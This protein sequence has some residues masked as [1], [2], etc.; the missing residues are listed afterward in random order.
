MAYPQDDTIFNLCYHVPTDDS[1]M[2]AS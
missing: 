2:F 1:R